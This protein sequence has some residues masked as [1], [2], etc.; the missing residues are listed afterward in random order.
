MQPSASPVPGL[1]DQA[2]CKQGRGSTDNTPTAA[3]RADGFFI[4]ARVVDLLKP[5]TK[6]MV[7]RPTDPLSIALSYEILRNGI[8]VLALAF[9]IVMLVGGGLDHIQGSLSAYYHFNPSAPTQYGAGT[10]RDAFVGMLC[11]IG[12]FLFFYRGHSLREDIALN[13]AGIAAVLVAFIPTD[14]PTVAGAST[15][16]KGTIHWVSATIFFVM[17]G[18]VCIFRA[19]DT[20]FLTHDAGRRIAFHRIYLCFG[21]LMLVTPAAAAISFKQSGHG[22]LTIEIC[23]IFV[24]SAFWLVKGYEIRSSFGMTLDAAFGEAP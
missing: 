5:A 12:A 24:F 3:R 11:A 20:L 9:P 23:G 10:M 2:A 18:Y 8:G 1:N 22:T 15:T 16:I 19:R 17:I 21:T 7:A 13:C 6:Q 4:A 14:W